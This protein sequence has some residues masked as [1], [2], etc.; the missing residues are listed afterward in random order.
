MD[1]RSY[2]ERRTESLY[3]SEDAA[4][5]RLSAS[6]YLISQAQWLACRCRP[7]TLFSFSLTAVLPATLDRRKTVVLAYSY[8][9][10]DCSIEQSNSSDSKLS[11]NYEYGAV[12]DG[13]REWLAGELATN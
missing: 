12:S 9:K 1:L 6:S 5:W 13:G 11:R 4:E 3:C 8:P 10:V 2:K 7:C